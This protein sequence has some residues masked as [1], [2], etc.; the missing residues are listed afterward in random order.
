MFLTWQGN[1]AYRTI[2]FVGM[3]FRQIRNISGPL[4]GVRL[5]PLQLSDSRERRGKKDIYE[6]VFLFVVTNPISGI[7]VSSSSCDVYTPLKFLYN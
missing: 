7:R 1:E 6:F 5:Y 2:H 4:S 3:G